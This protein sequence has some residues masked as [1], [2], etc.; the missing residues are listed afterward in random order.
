M[1]TGVRFTATAQAFTPAVASN[2]Q[3][4][5]PPMSV[6]MSGGLSSG[7]DGATFTPHVSEDGVL[8]WSN[9][10]NLPNPDPVYIRG[11][12]GRDGK[13]GK[14]GATG[15]KGADGQQ[16]PQGVQGPAGKD[17]QDGAKGDPGY[18]PVKGTDYWTDADKAEMVQ[19][20]LASLPVY[21]GE[22]ADV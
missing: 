21:N 1:D 5:T 3:S 17:G 6:A 7:Q 13:N 18:T 8:S 19:D 22:V 10:R 14:D 20:V 4:I 15:P 16:G 9:D 11:A 12:D 2:A